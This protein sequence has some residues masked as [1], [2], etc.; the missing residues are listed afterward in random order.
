MN[1]NEI[2]NVYIK[3]ANS[4][5]RRYSDCTIKTYLQFIDKYLDSLTKDLSTQQKEM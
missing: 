5:S 2:L 4:K 1:K 3:E